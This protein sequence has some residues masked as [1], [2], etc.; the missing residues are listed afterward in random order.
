MKTIAKSSFTIFVILSII[1]SAVSTLFSGTFFHDYNVNGIRDTSS[2]G[3]YEGGAVNIPVRLISCDDSSKDHVVAMTYTDEEGQY[4][5][6]I[7][8][9]EDGF[10]YNDELRVLLLSPCGFYPE[11]GRSEKAIVQPG[12]EVVWNVGIAGE[13]SSVLREYE[14]FDAVAEETTSTL[15]TTTEMVFINTQSTDY[16]DSF[17]SSNGADD[18]VTDIIDSLD[19]H[20]MLVDI[21]DNETALTLDT[22]DQLDNA[23]TI[24]PNT[25]N[26]VTSCL[27]CELRV[28]A[29]VGVQLDNID[30]KLNDDAR[31]LFENVCESFL[32]DQL[33]IATP[34]ISDISCVVV[35]ESF[36]T[37]LPGRSLRG[38]YNR[39]LSQVYV[40]DMNITGNAPSSNTYLTPQSIKFKELCVG[41]F[42]VQGEY[43]VRAL[44]EAEQNS[45]SND[46]VFQSVQN[47]RGVMT[48]DAS[49]VSEAGEQIDD[50]SNPEAVLRNR[51]HNF[52]NVEER[53][54][55]SNPDKLRKFAELSKTDLPIPSPTNS[56]VSGPTVIT[57]VSIRSNT[58]EVEVNII[59][60]SFSGYVERKQQS[61]TST[62]L[63]SRVRRDL[64]APPGKLGILV[65]NTAGFGPAVYSMQ[66]GS[67]MDGLIFVNDIIIAI[68]GINTRDCT[69]SQITQIM[70]ET[71]DQERKITVL[72]SV[73]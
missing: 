48:S 12:D 2:P 26:T 37:P 31:S 43:F 52:S 47:V 11:S 46:A 71:M 65:A 63:N 42:T 67:P 35:D 56:S 66:K 44:H 72:S 57:P 22:V 68:N 62:I 20:T 60:E 39:G 32:E 70:K 16:P 4:Y 30:S 19:N 45:D 13:Y 55:S 1:S 25:T 5:F 38:N 3:F 8:A 54:G 50:P 69:T 51:W 15:A 61:K 6:N 64:V 18:H 10:Y 24:A 27:G 36:E 23:T 58:N 49:E 14:I 59:P 53:S 28:Q 73:R 9:N 29:I 33:S 41:T 7:S 34:P 17:F 21:F 40:A